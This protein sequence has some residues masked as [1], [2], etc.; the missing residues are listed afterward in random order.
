MKQKIVQNCPNLF[1]FNFGTLSSSEFETRWCCNQS[2]F[3][4]EDVWNRTNLQAADYV[5]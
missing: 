3:V 4:M 5:S 1:K 2:V